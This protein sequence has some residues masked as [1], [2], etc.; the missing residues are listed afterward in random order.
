MKKVFILLTILS[1]IPSCSWIADAINDSIQKKEQEKIAKLEQQKKAEEAKN[2]E[3]AKHNRI[4]EL[5]S[6]YDKGLTKDISKE[7]IYDFDLYIEDIRKIDS[8]KAINIDIFMCDKYNMIDACFRAVEYYTKNKDKKKV[9]EI[10][11]ELFDWCT[12][13]GYELACIHINKLM[14]ISILNN[15]KYTLYDGAFL[16]SYLVFD[17][18]AGNIELEFIDVTNKVSM[19]FIMNNQWNYRSV[20]CFTSFDLAL[21]ENEKIEQYYTQKCILY[22]SL[23]GQGMFYNQGFDYQGAIKANKDYVYIEVPDYFINTNFGGISYKGY[24][25]KI[26]KKVGKE[27]Y[28]NLSTILMKNMKIEE[29]NYFKTKDNETN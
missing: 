10:T 2:K 7:N 11:E 13:S 27:I 4:Q 17:K 22:P 14:H 12:I 21:N 8:K 1:M 20:P 25:I 18:N 9:K 28:K 29:T 15:G 5:I 6:I 16:K 23:E 24:T 19:P 3:I 26:S